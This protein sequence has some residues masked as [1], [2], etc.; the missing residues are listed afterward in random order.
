MR[1]STPGP[2][3]TTCTNATTIVPARPRVKRS[4]DVG[5]EPD[6]PASND[7]FELWD[8]ENTAP[9]FGPAEDRPVT[10][11]PDTG[12]RAD[13]DRAHDDSQLTVITDSAVM[14]MRR[15]VESI[16]VESLAV[17]PVERTDD[18]STTT[19][20][21]RADDLVVPGRV[22]TRTESSL[23]SIRGFDNTTNR[24]VFDETT[25]P[26]TDR[27]ASAVPSSVA[28]MAVAGNV[29]VA[30]PEHTERHDAPRVSALRRLIGGLRFR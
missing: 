9:S 24:S 30:A 4:T 5:S 18:T 26:P 14:S 8:F 12:G 15:A 11:D 10:A 2:R 23:W 22:A 27:T 7:T 13:S 1:S 25:P 21:V 28:A 20:A 29:P 6:E 3:S 17:R 19:G 16:E